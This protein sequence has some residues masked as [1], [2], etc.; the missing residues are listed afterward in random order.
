MSE[1]YF[2]STVP[3]TGELDPTEFSSE[4]QTTTGTSE[5]SIMGK[6][7]I[8]VIM[9]VVVC[10]FVLGC[11]RDP[12]PLGQAPST[13]EI[14]AGT[15]NAVEEG[16]EP[17]EEEGGE[18]AEEESGEATEEEGGEPAEEESG[19]AEEEGSELAEEESGEAEEEGGETEEEGAEA[20]EQTDE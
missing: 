7:S 19:E 10:S 2:N 4:I 13:G 6:N 20:D 16:V 3:S 18:P 17:I 12:S 11:L 9:L 5:E 15:A 8:L 1:L 14:D